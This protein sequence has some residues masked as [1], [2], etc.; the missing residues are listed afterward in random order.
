MK[1]QQSELLTQFYEDYLAWAIAGGHYDK[2]FTCRAGLCWNLHLWADEPAEVFNDLSHEL[3]DQLAKVYG[4][5]DYPFNDR[6]MHYSLEADE[7][8]AHQNERRIAW[9]KSH[10]EDGS[11]TQT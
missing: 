6:G 7:R 3:Q 4:E 11:S 1:T 8:S 5:N 9:V 10:V 2:R